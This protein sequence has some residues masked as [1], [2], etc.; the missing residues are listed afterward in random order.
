MQN[1]N[2][3]QA[4]RGQA[5]GLLLQTESEGP[6]FCSDPVYQQ[7]PLFIKFSEMS[8]HLPNSGT[9]PSSHFTI[10]LVIKTLIDST[11][12]TSEKYCVL[13]RIV[14]LLDYVH[15]RNLSTL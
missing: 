7:V 15:L 6:L 13:Q 9:L 3:A 14:F 4:C 2:Q 1:P 11:T 10:A 5:G 8:P 12:G